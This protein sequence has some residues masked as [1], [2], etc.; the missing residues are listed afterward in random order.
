MPGCFAYTDLDAVFTMVVSGGQASYGLTVPNQA[1]L[2]GFELAAQSSVF[3]PTANAFGFINSNRLL[4]S[5][6]Y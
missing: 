4:L 2:I 3:A 6:D 1:N 5:L